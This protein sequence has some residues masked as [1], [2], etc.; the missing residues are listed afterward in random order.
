[1]LKKCFLLLALAA[2]SSF[3]A[4]RVEIT[5]KNPSKMVRDFEV[6]EVPM[7][8]I[9]NA[10]GADGFII[11]DA[12]GK[13]LPSQLTGNNTVLFQVSVGG[14][15]KSVY[16]AVKGTPSRYEKK[17]MGRLFTERQDEFGW[18][19]DRVAYRVFGHGAAVGYDL[20]NKSTSRLML[21]YWYAS[22]QD[23]E[24]RSVCRKLRDR[25]Q[26]ELADKVYNA[27]CYHI[28][29]GQGMDCYTVGNT[30]GAG[31]N[32]L[33][34]ADGS[35][36]L[37]KCYK[38]YE[39]VDDGPLRFSVKFTYPEVEYD[40]KTVMETRLITIDAGTAFCRVDVRYHEISAPVTMASG[41]VVHNSNPAAFVV[42]KEAGYLGYEDLGDG[43]V[44]NPKYRKELE[45][46]MGRIYI[47][48][49]Y[50]KP[51]SD[52]KFTDYNSGIAVGHVLAYAQ[53]KPFEDYTY[54]FGSAWSGNEETSVKSLRDWEA[55]LSS[56]ATVVRNPLKVTV[57]VK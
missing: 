9:K 47:G 18:E 52:M 46:Q 48:T 13:E 24:M 6:V 12:D 57:K 25:G 37:P 29:H 16:Y 44:Y 20:F 5:V 19:N 17:V 36:C 55:L 11:T 50:P 23:G 45:R 49:V 28:D 40:G 14:Q 3:A 10:F 31:A 39:I 34:N 41:V 22:E 33:V 21:D 4:E 8:G 35:L 54:Y 43:S 32:A 51:V 53:V 56:Q 42:N 2:S 38:S 30:L 26:A 27:F 15:K 1:M 7:T